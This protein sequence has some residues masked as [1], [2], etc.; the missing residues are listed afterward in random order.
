MLKTNTIE[1]TGNENWT[2]TVKCFLNKNGEE[3]TTSQ[4]QHANGESYFPLK[5]GFEKNIA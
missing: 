3:F 2:T 4:L 5:I 1:P